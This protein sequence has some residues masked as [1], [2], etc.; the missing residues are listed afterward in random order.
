[1]KRGSWTIPRMALLGAL[2]GVTFGMVRVGGEPGAQTPVV[3]YLCRWLIRHFPGIVNL[4]AQA[5]P[6]R[7]AYTGVCHS[8][9][10]LCELAEGQIL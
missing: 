3:A 4:D 2:L 9:N 1:M 7:R 10:H 6:S 8:G 5:R